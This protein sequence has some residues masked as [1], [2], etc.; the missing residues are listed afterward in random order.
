MENAFIFKGRLCLS[1]ACLGKRWTSC[2]T[3]VKQAFAYLMQLGDGGDVPEAVGSQIPAVVKAQL[4]KT[5]AA[6]VLHRR[7]DVDDLVRDARHMPQ[8]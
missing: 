6:I 8:R 7:Q 2:E 4:P 1:R 5:T 3:A